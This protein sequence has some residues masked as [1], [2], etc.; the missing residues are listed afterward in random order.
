MVAKEKKILVRTLSTVYMYSQCTLFRAVSEAKKV[1]KVCLYL[2][3]FE[4]FILRLPKMEHCK[5]NWH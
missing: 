1:A 5:T 3:E 2:N 4:Y